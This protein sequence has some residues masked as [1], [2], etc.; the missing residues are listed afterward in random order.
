MKRFVAVSLS[1]ALALA[2]FAGCSGKA[3]APRKPGELRL[4]TST[5]PMYL[6]TRNVVAGRGEVTVEA[7]L[8][9]SAGCP[10]DYALT[11]GDLRKI[12]RADV[13]VVNGL[14]LEEFLGSPV[15]RANPK[16]TVLDSSKGIDELLKLTAE[17]GGSAE[18]AHHHH[19]DI[20]PHLFAS[21][22][23]AAKIARNIAEQLSK[24]DPA[25]A[26]VY[27]KNAQGYASR[28][29]ALAREFPP[30]G[31]RLARKIVTEH[32]VF[33]YFARDAGLDIVAVVEED[34]GQTPSGPEMMRIIDTIRKSG[35]AAVFTEPQYSTKVSATIAAEAK[36]PVASLDPVASGP[37]DAPLDY[38]EKT[39][40]KNFETLA[41][42][43]GK[44]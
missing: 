38:Y 15:T 33:D 34:P 17:E 44:E 36:A 1:I 8:P 19:G 27:R 16:L 32:A 18:D 10:H 23:M 11:P 37:D 4:L 31:K 30:A 6:F 12:A 28:L 39:M 35:A 25:G 2:A 40:R 24:I 41:K 7:M 5:F 21:P 3:A 26:E 14:G 9:G 22:R 20:N 42:V 29:E 43:L 13:F